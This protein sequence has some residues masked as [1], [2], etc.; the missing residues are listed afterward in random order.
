MLL[1]TSFVI[2]IYSFE[3]F[4]N[5]I[6]SF[7]VHLAALGLEIIVHVLIPNHPGHNYTECPLSATDRNT[8]V[9]ISL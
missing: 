4:K 5:I 3:K 9:I 1:Q 8:G 7:F 6:I 2:I